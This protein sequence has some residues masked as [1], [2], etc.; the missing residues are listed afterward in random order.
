M[1]YSQKRKEEIRKDQLNR[2]KERKTKED[3]LNAKK[4]DKIFKINDE[5]CLIYINNYHHII[6]YLFFKSNDIT[7]ILFLNPSFTIIFFYRLN[8]FKKYF[9]KLKRTLIKHLKRKNMLLLL[10]KRNKHY[11]Y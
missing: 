1:Y 10:L 6:H 3:A 8:T 5:V 2:S 7:I 9:Q 11:I 4:I